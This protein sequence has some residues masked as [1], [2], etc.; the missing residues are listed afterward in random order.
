MARA[1]IVQ[2]VKDHRNTTFEKL[3]EIFP[4]TIVPTYGVFAELSVAKKRSAE[5][6][7][8]FIKPEQV[9]KLKDKT[10]TVTNQWTSVYI[11]KFLIEAKKHG[12]RATSA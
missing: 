11:A 12:Y 1:I 10:I 5:K 9:I 2:F 3:K 4:D 7:R 6:Q 8:Y